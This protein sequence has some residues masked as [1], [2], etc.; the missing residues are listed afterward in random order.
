MKRRPE[1][2]VIATLA[3]VLLAGCATPPE[4]PPDTRALR[5][6]RRAEAAIPLADRAAMIEARLFSDFYHEEPELVATHLRI[7]DGRTEKGP[8]HAEQN[9]HLL[10][11][12]AFKFAAT[13][14][15]S[16]EERARRLVAGLDAMDAANGMDGFLPLEVLPER[17]GLTVVNDRFV[18]SS[19]VQLLQ[20]QVLA[21]RL[22]ADPGLKSAIRAQALRMLE[23]LRAH[24]L[25]VVDA[26]GRPLPYSDA[27]LSRNFFGTSSELETLVFV[28]AGCFFA[29]GDPGSEA[30]WGA[31]RRRMEVDYKYA[32]LPFILHVRLP[33]LE[34]PTVSS[35]WLNLIK[36]SALAEITGSAKYRRLLGG[37]ADDYRAH[38]NPY[39][40]GLDLLHGPELSADRR[41]RLLRKAWAR[42]ETYPL[43]NT[44][45]E[46]SNL[47]RGGH[48][49]EMPPR[50]IKNAWALQSTKPVPFYDQPGDRYLWKRNLR[51][52]EGNRGDP[53][54][55]I[56]AGVDFFEAYWL[57]R[58]AGE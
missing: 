39:F 30:E 46:L 53:G 44:S 20:A 9:A 18:A 17:G 21:W 8:V 55:R 33:F 38:E 31:L 4:E 52:L 32:A 13:G 22:F 26:E 58:Y 48:R 35:S 50:W 11:G 45:L 25:V 42:L 56:Y 5:E 47:G 28:H 37:L 27:S 43:T 6:L 51:L 41:Q 54:D 1:F 40:I 29:Q 10:A 15:P 16:A 12:L 7:A 23:R 24:E 49:L 36:L 19:Y 14:D 3:V 34:A 2:P 57:L